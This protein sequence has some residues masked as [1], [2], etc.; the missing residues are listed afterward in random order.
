MRQGGFM[1]EEKKGTAKKA[2][3]KAKRIALIVAASLV[4]VSAASVL[5]AITI[6]D[7]VFERYER[8]D[9]ALYPGLYSYERVADRLPRE[10]FR[11]PSG[12][13]MLQA[14]YYPSEN[15][16]GLIVLAHGFHAG[17]DDYLPLILA[18]VEREYA[19][20][21][22]DVTGVY[23]SEGESVV[24]MCQ[25][26]RDLDCVLTYAGRE[27][28]F[29]AMA[30]FVIGHSWGGYAASS[31]LA[32]HSEIQGAALL[33]PMNNGSQMI[34]EKGEQYAGKVAYSAKPIFDTYQRI[35]FG[36]YV[37]YNGVVGINSTDAPILIAQGVDDTVITPD[38]QSIT[39]HLPELTNP[40]I[41]LYWGKGSQGSHTG[42]WHSTE[43]EEYARVVKSQLK[44]RELELERALNDEEKKEF[45]ATVDHELYS[46][47]NEE[48][49]DLIVQTF[50]KGLNS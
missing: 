6:Y 18:M 34:L 5:S 20:L 31:V 17:A 23:S 28:R 42:I 25:S 24:G 37:K 13:V 47:V 48:L 8:P 4:G 9:Y 45:Y 49:M 46:G 12:D 40:N 2:S 3:S 35:L 33:A 41:T 26:L 27:E 39:A 1:S 7:S 32:L 36:N 50:E 43:A 22:Y 19:V 44:L 14:Y 10:T 21:T 38:G 30:K 29:S 11:I 15:A 16:R